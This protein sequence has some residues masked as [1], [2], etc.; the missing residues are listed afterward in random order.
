MMHCRTWHLS[1]ESK[2]FDRV[3]K[4]LSILKSWTGDP[5]T[6][7]FSGT[8][9]YE[10]TFE[11]SVNYIRDNISL[12][13]DPGRVGNIADVRINGREAGVV[14]MTGQ[15]LEITGLVQ[16]GENTLELY[17]TNTNINRV[18][19]FQ[20]PLPVPPDLHQKFGKG[21]SGESTRN[22][23]EFGFEPLPASGLLGPV[24]IIPRKKVVI[25]LN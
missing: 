11:I 23:R 18:S 15:T 17:V 2:H 24:K 10:I 25:S 19:A 14:W 12:H 21:K 3:E 16:A 4:E 7:N 5:D 6:R 1:L 8:G 13:L 20:E 9:R 22:P